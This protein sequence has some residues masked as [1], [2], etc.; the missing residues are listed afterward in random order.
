MLNQK[1][2]KTKGIFALIFLAALYAGTGVI[3]RFLSL[4]FTLLQQTYLRAFLAFFLGLL[5]FRNLDFKKLTHISHSEWLLL[6]SRTAASFL[7]AMPL[8]IAGTNNAKLANVTFIDALPITATFS[9]VLGREKAT[10]RKVFYL[11]L[12]FIGILLLSIK[13]FSHILTSFGYGEFLVLLSGFFFAFR[14]YSRTWHSKLLNDAE[15]TQLMFFFGFIIVLCTSLLFGEG[16]PI[17]SGSTELVLMLPVGGLV[18]AL[19]IFLM[20]YGFA[21]I[22]AVLGN[23][24]LNLEAAF[25]ILFG[26]TFYQEIPNIRELIGGAFIIFSVIKMHQME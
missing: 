4:H 7:L 19:N 5:I 16:I 22:S 24:I 13:D 14:N 11:F 21:K 1:S 25:G 15:I 10:L 26:F 23:N 3:T 18:L 20:N 9:F 8:W 2:D 17:P 6:L 12:S